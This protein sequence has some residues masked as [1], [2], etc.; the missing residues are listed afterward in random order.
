MR[1][2]SARSEC[3]MVCY[4]FDSGSLH[5]QQLFRDRLHGEVMLQP[6]HTLYM[7]VGFAL[8][9]QP[10]VDLQDVPLFYTLILSG[11]ACWL[12]CAS[13]RLLPYWIGDVLH[14]RIDS[15]HW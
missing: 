1:D 2:L 6:G 15:S 10:A 3:A 14:V 12:R 9:G 11:Q 13:D 7:V 4:R 5:P 8:C